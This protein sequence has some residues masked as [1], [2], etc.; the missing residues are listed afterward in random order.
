MFLTAVQWSTPGLLWYLPARLI[1]RHTS[2]LVHSIAYMIE[3]MAK[4]REHLSFSLS[5]L[6]WSGIESYST[7]HLVTQARTPSLTVPFWITSKSCQGIYSLKN[8]SSV[9][10]YL[11][12]SWSSICKQLHRSLSLKNSFQ[13]LLYAF[14]KILHHFWS[15]ICHS[16]ILIKKVVVLPL[17][18]L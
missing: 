9:L 16:H 8:L 4:H 7:S 18:Y 3:P 14:Q 11:Y 6:Q 17:T 12:R 13:T 15:T 10:I 5:L 2:G 1:A